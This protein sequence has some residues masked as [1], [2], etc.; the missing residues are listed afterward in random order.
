MTDIRSSWVDSVTTQSR[1]LTLGHGVEDSLTTLDGQKLIVV[2]PGNPGMG[3]MYQDFMR[4]LSECLD[5][6]RL[7][8]WSFSYV[9]HDTQ[10]PPTLPTAPTYDL[11]DQIEH[12]IALLKKLVPRTTQL[13]L[14]GHSIGCKICM[15]IFKRNNSHT[16]RDVYF[17]F[18]TIEN[19]VTTDRGRQVLPWVTSFRLLAVAIMCVLS[20]IPDFLL[21]VLLKMRYSKASSKFVAATLDFVNSNHLNN[22]LML[23][24]NE[25]ETV[26][27][28]D[29]DTIR[30]MIGK[31]HILFG[32]DDGWSPLTYRDN[33]LRTVPDFPETEA[34]IDSGNIP[35]AFVEFNSEVTAT[36]VADWIKK[37]EN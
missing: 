36:I 9:G 35:H 3:A 17:L 15:E 30:A 10:T 14:I 31:L 23:A 37:K 19:M 20:L 32:K 6:A 27:D 8:I 34:V 13:T 7:S 4:V 2:I 21:R 12:K 5:D 22:C 25:L 26:L 28:L 24:K 11:E 33:L 18:P 29:A 16:I 1:V